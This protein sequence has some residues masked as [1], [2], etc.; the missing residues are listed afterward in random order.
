MV[1]RLVSPHPTPLLPHAG[2]VQKSHAHALASGF[3]LL[4]SL[5]H[6]PGPEVECSKAL[7]LSVYKGSHIRNSLG[8]NCI[9]RL[10]SRA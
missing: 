10:T 8:S 3:L 9:A 4:M 6:R 2:A 1:G 5:T 7:H